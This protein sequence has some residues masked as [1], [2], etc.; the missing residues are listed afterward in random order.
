MLEAGGAAWVASGLVS[1][2]HGAAHG[3]CGERALGAIHRGLQWCSGSSF[4]AG[5][6]P[7]FP[8]KRI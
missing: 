5:L 1:G 3:G 6:R 8:T 7:G 4:R 2:S